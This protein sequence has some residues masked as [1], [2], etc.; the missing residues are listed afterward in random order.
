MCRFLCIFDHYLRQ[1]EATFRTSNAMKQKHKT[2][3]VIADD[4]PIVL[5]QLEQ[6]FVNST[7]FD[8]IK[9]FLDLKSAL[10]FI[11]KSS[12]DLFIADIEF[13]H[14]ELSYNILSRIPYTP[15]VLISAHGNHFLWGHDTIRRSR[16]V[17]GTVPKPI[18]ED[19]VQEILSL[20][21]SIKQ[22]GLDKSAIKNNAFNTTIL[23]Q[24]ENSPRQIEIRYSQIAMITSSRTP[25]GLAFYLNDAKKPY[26]LFAGQLQTCFNE[27]NQQ[28][29]GLFYLIPHVGIVN[30]W[31]MTLNGNFMEATRSNIEHRLA[32]PRTL[33][34]S[35][36]NI[37]QEWST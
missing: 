6:A 19:I 31:N 8:L 26:Y 3:C 13:P 30:L 18:T 1:S 2:I 4:D 36:K 34:C 17:I 28:C 15:V 33:Q 16:N 14:E 21:Q 20:Y 24:R 22:Q 9:V 11:K 29:P 12:V 35:L 25:R 7:Y 5:K 32:V 23:L 37:K 27:L 10:Q